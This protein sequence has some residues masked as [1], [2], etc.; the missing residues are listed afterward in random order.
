[1][2]CKGVSQS[3]IAGNID[4][5]L[6]QFP[7]LQNLAFK[8]KGWQL[9]KANFKIPFLHAL[10]LAVANC[11]PH[12]VVANQ[13]IALKLQ[14]GYLSFQLKTGHLA[15][16][17]CFQHDPSVPSADS[18]PP[19]TPADRSAKCLKHVKNERPCG[20]KQFWPN[21]VCTRCLSADDIPPWYASTPPQIFEKDDVTLW[22]DLKPFFLSPIGSVDWQNGVPSPC[23]HI[24]LLV[25]LSPLMIRLIISILSSWFSCRC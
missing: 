24:F 18:M 25:F 16:Q 9:H 10:S 7:D 19:G 2:A 14:T 4:T 8:K 3:H 23:H 12:V 20:K 17:H 11:P 13:S 6:L 15:F 5:A 1:M 22:Y 21:A